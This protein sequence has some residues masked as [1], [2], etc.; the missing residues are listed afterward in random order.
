M[1]QPAAGT[2]QGRRAGRNK[3][4]E[5]STSLAG[6]PTSLKR[7]ARCREIFGEAAIPPVLGHGLNW[8]VRNDEVT[9]E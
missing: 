4:G 3:S 1:E 6:G 9:K 7:G 8:E 5:P 2:D